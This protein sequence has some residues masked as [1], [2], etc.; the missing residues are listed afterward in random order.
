MDLQAYLDILRRRGW[1]IIVVAV[2]GAVAALG[3]GQVQ[4][5]IYR[6]HRPHRARSGTPDWGLGN[7]AKDLLATSSTTSAPT[8]WPTG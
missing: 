8:T 4:T 7:S 1:I 3:V 5:R 2:I 6:G